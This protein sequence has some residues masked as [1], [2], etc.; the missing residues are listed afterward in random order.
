[1]KGTKLKPKNQRKL[2]D[3]IIYFDSGSPKEETEKERSKKLKR[4]KQQKTSRK[5]NRKK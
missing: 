4:R 1:M 2:K 3:R 5:N